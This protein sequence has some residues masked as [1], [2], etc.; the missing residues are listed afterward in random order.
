MPENPPKETDFI[1]SEEFLHG[2]MKRQLKLSVTCATAF[3]ILLFGLPLLNYLAPVFMAR[4]VGGFTLTWL[5]LGVLFFPYV[6]VIAR[7]FI[8]RSMALEDAEV[9]NAAEGNKRKN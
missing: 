4:R 2:L 8:T 6:W 5:I 3:V 7:I 1:H 9:V